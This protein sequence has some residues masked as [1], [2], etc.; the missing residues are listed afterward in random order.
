EG[1][2]G[3]AF[4]NTADAPAE[5]ALEFYSDAGESLGHE[6]LSLEAHEKRVGRPERLFGQYTLDAGYLE[7]SADR[8]VVGFQLNAGPD[9]MMLDALPGM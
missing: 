4:V 3:I 8:E 7:F 5:I 6:S 9:D 1:W 2:T